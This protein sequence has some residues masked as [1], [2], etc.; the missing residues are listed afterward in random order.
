MASNT[1]EMAE[2]AQGLSSAE[3]AARLVQYGPN[4]LK[5]RRQAVLWQFLARFRNTLVLI[6]LMASILSAATSA[7]VIAVMVLMSV[8][9]DFVQEYRA[10]LAAE[11]LARQVALCV[12]VVRD[13]REQEVRAE[14]LVPGDVLLL[15]AGDLVPADAQV[16]Q[17][18]DFFVNQALLTGEPYP[19]ERHAAAAV[20]PE[21][22]DWD[23]DAPDAL[24]MGRVDRTAQL[25]V[26][27]RRHSNGPGP[28]EGA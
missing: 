14:T 1:I 27:Q 5:P 3:A 10:G 18:K 22:G 11:N 9:L 16:L 15:S 13:A 6:L 4:Q 26:D 28:D 25:F 20:L 17:A 23:V 24:F 21:E 12:R 19:V 7:T 8:I 2:A